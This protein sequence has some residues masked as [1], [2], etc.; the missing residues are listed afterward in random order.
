MLRRHGGYSETNGKQKTCTYMT[1]LFTELRR[2]DFN[3]KRLDGSCR[4]GLSV[5]RLIHDIYCGG[6]ACRHIQFIMKQLLCGEGGFNL[7]AFESKSDKQY[8]NC[9]LFEHT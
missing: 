4:C 1:E 7:S 6:S 2:T 3:R 9:S 8:N 5:S